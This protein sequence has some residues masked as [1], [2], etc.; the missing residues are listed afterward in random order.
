MISVWWITRIK[1]AGQPAARF[2]GSSN[3]GLLQQFKNW[4][5]G[6]DGGRHAILLLEQLRDVIDSATESGKAVSRLDEHDSVRSVVKFGISVRLFRSHLNSVSN[7]NSSKW[8]GRAH[9]LWSE[10]SRVSMAAKDWG[11]DNFLG[12]T[13]EPVRL[14]WLFFSLLLF[15]SKCD[16]QKFWSLVGV[17][18]YIALLLADIATTF[19]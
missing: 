3:N 4:T 15:W 12:S 14:P 18:R 17:I 1:Y 8:C 7:D 19:P 2:D 10:M 6:I 16:M 13:L 11:M 9:R 5:L